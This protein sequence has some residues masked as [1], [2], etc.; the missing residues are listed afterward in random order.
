M[1]GKISN[2]IL[3]CHKYVEDVTFLSLFTLNSQVG[4][5][6]GECDILVDMQANSIRILRSMTQEAK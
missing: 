6:S 2:V 3:L 1:R 4:G 5:S